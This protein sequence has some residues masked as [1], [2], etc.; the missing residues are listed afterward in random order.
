VRARDLGIVIGALPTG[1]H[2]A[3]TDVPGVL[4]GH[5]TIVAGSDI[6][7]GVTAERGRLWVTWSFGFGTRP[8]LFVRRSN[9]AVTKFGK[10]RRVPLPPGTTTVWKVYTSAH[11]GRLEVVALVSRHGNN[12]KAAYW[13]TQVLPP[14]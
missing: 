2:N 9:T 13:A 1:R 10:V 8:G 7:T 4:V 14:R 5:T 3:I 11:A 6:R 12:N